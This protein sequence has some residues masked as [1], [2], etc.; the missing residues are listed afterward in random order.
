MHTAIRRS[1]TVNF[2]G[3]GTDYMVRCKYNYSTTFPG[4]NKKKMAGNISKDYHFLQCFIYIEAIS[5]IDEKAGFSIS[6]DAVSSTP[7]PEMENW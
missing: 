7:C 3:D 5:H 6:N 4:T 1:G 2:S